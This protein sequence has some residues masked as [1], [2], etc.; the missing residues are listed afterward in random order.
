MKRVLLAAAAVLAATVAQAQTIYVTPNS[1]TPWHS[2]AAFK[3]VVSGNAKLLTVEPGVTDRDL[4]VVANEP[5]DDTLIASTN[6]LMFDD[7]GKLVENLRVIV[8]P[9]GGPSITLRLGQ[10]TYHCG[11][12]CM[13]ADRKKGLGD[14]DSRTVTTRK[15]GSTSTWTHTSTPP[16][17]PGAP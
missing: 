8:T 7:Q 1:A 9:F 10:T 5:A 6:V 12:S 17:P 13:N 14:A 3:R 16:T 15:D 2:K 4:I 11:M